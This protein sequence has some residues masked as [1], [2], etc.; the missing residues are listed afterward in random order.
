MPLTRAQEREILEYFLAEVLRLDDPEDPI[1]K[2]FRVLEITT[3]TDF[4][5]ADN[6]DF[7]NEIYEDPNEDATTSHKTLGRAQARRC[8]LLRNMA[9]VI[10]TEEGAVP[11]INGWRAAVTPETF[12]LFTANPRLPVPDAGMAPIVQPPAAP[13][14]SQAAAFLRGN[15]RDISAYPELKDILKFT[16]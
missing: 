7:G 6:K 14:T 15:K 12:L 8:E 5:S 3:L 9:S 1:R 2:V 16:T 4:I 13:V 11:D 10:I